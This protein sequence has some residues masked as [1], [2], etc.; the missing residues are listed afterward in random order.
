[1]KPIELNILS[2]FVRTWLWGVYSLCEGKGKF[3]GFWCKGRGQ[4][5]HRFQVF[6][7]MVTSSASSTV[8]ELVFSLLLIIAHDITLSEEV[9]QNISSC[10][11]IQ[12]QILQ[13]QSPQLSDGHLCMDYRREINIQWVALLRW[14]C[15][16]DKT[17]SNPHIFLF[18][19]SFLAFEYS[20]YYRSVV[21][22]TQAV[23]PRSQLR[24]VLFYSC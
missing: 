16:L 15:N 11:V 4:T 5:D 14:L 6:H 3:R 10:S 7:L 18:K 21:L 17:T 20:E 1:M 13:I 12:V 22:T 24:F 19:T 2:K 8:L 23:W 9:W